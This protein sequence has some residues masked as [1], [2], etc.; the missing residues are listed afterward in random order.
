MNTPN[1]RS[2]EQ[3]V[4]MIYAA[5]CPFVLYVDSETLV[6]RKEFEKSISDKLTI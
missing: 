1:I 4:P 3:V 5:D 6:K 2:F